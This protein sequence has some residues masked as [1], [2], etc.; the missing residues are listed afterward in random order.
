MS[1]GSIL[2]GSGS[3]SPWTSA[4]HL[5]LCIPYHA[6][7]K[8]LSPVPTFTS[9]PR[10]P[11]VGWQTIRGGTRSRACVN[12]R[13]VCARASPGRQGSAR[14]GLAA[15]LEPQPCT[16]AVLPPA[17]LDFLSSRCYFSVES[18]LPSPSLVSRALGPLS[19]LSCF[20][21]VPLFH[22]R[23]AHSLSGLTPTPKHL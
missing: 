2:R 23:R 10:C 22:P 11:G 9:A 21:L 13:S 7:H 19:S 14:G 16:E 6:D 1:G 17:H 12:D 5:S 20:I 8:S 4:L 15:L 3:F 18:S